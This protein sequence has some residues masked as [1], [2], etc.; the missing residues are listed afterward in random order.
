MVLQVSPQLQGQTRQKDAEARAITAGADADRSSPPETQPTQALQDGVGGPQGDCRGL[1]EEQSDSPQAQPRLRW[2]DESWRTAGESRHHSNTEAL[3]RVDNL[4]KLLCKNVYQS[5][6]HV[7][8]TTLL[9]LL[10][11]RYHII[12]MKQLVKDV[13]KK[14]VTCPRIL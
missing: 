2:T 6:L 14:C 11:L 12:G 8:P 1:Q 9:S 13:S 5:N 3:H 7:G 4:S 10:C